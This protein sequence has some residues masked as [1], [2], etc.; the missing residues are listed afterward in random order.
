VICNG[1]DSNWIKVTSGVP[2]S[3][4]LGP[5]LFLIYVNDMDVD[6]VSSL[7]KFADDTKLFRKV[8]DNQQVEILRADLRRLCEWSEKWQMSFNIDKCKVMHLGHNNNN[9]EYFIDC[10]ALGKI[11]EEKYL[12]VLI[13]NDFKV[14]KHCAM[15]AKKGNKVLGM[16]NRTFEGRSKKMM[17]KLYKTL[18]RPHLDYCIQA[19]RPS[20]CKDISLIE[21]VQ[22]RATR[23]M[24]ECRGLW[25]ETRLQTVRLT[26]LEVRHHRADLIEVIKILK[27]LEG[28]RRDD[29]FE[30][31]NSRTRGHMLKLKKN[32]FRT[33]IGK[34]TF[35]NRVVNSWNKLP[36]E[37]VNATSL[38]MF[39]G[40][41][42]RHLEGIGG[43]R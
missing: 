27:G 22:K 26:S 12:G 43:T 36:E 8:A 28:L 16:I 41:L 38:N 37:V 42:D 3:S 24:E 32:R 15:A 19:W 33:N 23:M 18:V 17:S 11:T 39:K 34:N 25:Y 13:S 2:Q 4:V 31:A 14:T 10:K 29:F 21:K 20:L 9:A 1:K 5:V 30:L 7:L 35:S 6:I 40:K